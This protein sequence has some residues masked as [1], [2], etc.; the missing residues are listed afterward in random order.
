[1][2]PVGICAVVAY[3]NSPRIR[4]DGPVGLAVIGTVVLFSPYSR[5]WSPDADWF[6]G[7]GRI[8]PV[9]AGMVPN[10]LT[11]HSRASDSPRIRGD[12]PRQVMP[13]AAAVLFSPYSRG[14]SHPQHRTTLPLRILP[15]FA[16]MVRSKWV[17]TL[18]Y[19]IFSPYSRGW[20]PADSCVHGIVNI[21]PVFAGMVPDSV[22]FPAVYLHSPRIR[23]DGPS[24]AHIQ[25]LWSLFSP[26]S[27]GWSD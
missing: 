5:G 15:V 4:G 11:S 24:A 23:G 18:C 9:F 17:I 1:M 3:S 22:C 2:V 19:T 8:L 7:A 10:R 16:G 20:S 27:R 13:L 6:A 12:G 25:T 14:W 21:L 26:Y